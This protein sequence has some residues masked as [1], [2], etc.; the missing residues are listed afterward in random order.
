MSILDNLFKSEDR[1]N[2]YLKNLEENLM[3]FQ[4]VTGFRIEDFFKLYL[5]GAIYFKTD[6]SQSVDILKM[7]IGRCGINE[8]MKNIHVINIKNIDYELDIKTDDDIE[9]TPS[10]EKKEEKEINKNE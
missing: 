1:K 10:F 8:V 3:K 6:I 9:N 5:S 2:E 4:K 7:A